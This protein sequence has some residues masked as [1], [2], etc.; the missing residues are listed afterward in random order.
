MANF[1]KQLF[2]FPSKRNVT[3]QGP[4]PV[5]ITETPEGQ[6]LKQTLEQRMSG[7]GVGFSPEF[8]SATTAPYAQA[9]RE[10]LTRY[11]VPQ[12]SAEASARGVGRSTIPVSRIALSSQEASRDI[13]QRV[14]QATELQEKQKRA[15]INDALAR[16]QQFTGDAVSTQNMKAQFDYA[17]YLQQIGRADEAEKARTAALQ[18]IAMTT[19][20]FIAG[21]VTTSPTGT[22]TGFSPLAGFKAMT[23]QTATQQLIDEIFK[24]RKNPALVARSENA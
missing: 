14:A 1:F 19:G 10:Q 17:D 5:S 24:T 22:V 12:I 11:E 18:K 4:K 8:V 23:G 16:Y 6:K 3:Y 21:G 15:E 9:R 13:E 2:G 20:G 7:L